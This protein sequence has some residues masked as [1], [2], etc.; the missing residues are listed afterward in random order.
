MFRRFFPHSNS[1][2]PSGGTD[3]AHDAAIARE[4]A[5]AGDL[6]HA[7]YHIGCALSTDPSNVTWLAFL[8]ELI[9]RAG[10]D[11]LILAP[12]GQE[13]HF[14]LVAVRAGPAPLSWSGKDYATCW[15]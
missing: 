12:L 1:A 8:N 10:S 15:C 9:A 6:R 2:L 4:A 7:A 14:A 3:P 13:P 5:T 11:P